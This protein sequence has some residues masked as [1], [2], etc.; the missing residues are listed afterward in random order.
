MQT[1]NKERVLATALKMFLKSGLRAVR[2]DD[3]AYECGISKRTLY[4]LFENREELIEAALETATS[5]IK[6]C[7]S[8]ASK[9]AENILHAFWLVFTDTKSSNCAINSTIVEELRRYYPQIMERL[10]IK[11]HEE[12]V[13]HTR[14]KLTEGVENGLIMPNLNLDFFSR[15]LTNYIY[16]LRVIESNTATTGLVLTE[17]TVPSAIIIFLRGISTEK[18]RDYID[19]NLLKHII[20]EK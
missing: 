10:L 4:E 8:E 18:G 13:I 14:E 1:E 11:H 17:R 16:G 9:R 5:V 12:I 2:M 20:E 6:Q 7:E 3:I 15:A 19:K